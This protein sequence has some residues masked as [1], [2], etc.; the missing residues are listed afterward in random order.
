[1]LQ[2]NACPV[3]SDERRYRSF[4]N[5][6][7]VAGLHLPLLHHQEASANALVLFFNIPRISSQTTASIWRWTWRRSILRCGTIANGK[8][9]MYRPHPLTPIQYPVVQRTNLLSAFDVPIPGGSNLRKSVCK[10]GLSRLEPGQ[11]MIGYPNISKADLRLILTR[12][13]RSTTKMVEAY[14]K[15]EPML[16]SLA[17]V[18]VGV[19]ITMLHGS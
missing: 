4:D 2:I 13:S 15:P 14:Y 17:T 10:H 3:K 8:G 1:M 7:L 16:A 12:S 19:F 18:T 9:K 6:E 11:T 5:L